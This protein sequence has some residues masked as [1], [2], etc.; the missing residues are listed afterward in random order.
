M[1][2]RPGL[3]RTRGLL[4]RPAV[5]FCVQYFRLDHLHGRNFHHSERVLSSSSPVTTPGAST[6][7]VHPPAAAA[8]RR[9]PRPRTLPLRPQQ[10]M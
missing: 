9:I 2:C 3:C 1:A 10:H 5:A 7:T 4:I 8:D 6:A